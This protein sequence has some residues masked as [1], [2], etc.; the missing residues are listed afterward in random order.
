M[1]LRLR[2]AGRGVVPGAP[3]GALGDV[4]PKRRQAGWKVVSDVE[5]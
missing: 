5:Q 4:G 3:S 1:E 2:D